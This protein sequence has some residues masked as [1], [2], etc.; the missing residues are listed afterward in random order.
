[1]FQKKPVIILLVISIM[2]LIISALVIVYLGNE[3]EMNANKNKTD[4]AKRETI[5]FPRKKNQKSIKKKKRKKSSIDK[6]LSKLELSES[7]KLKIMEIQKEK[8]LKK[9]EQKKIKKLKKKLSRSF[10]DNTSYE[11][12][13]R[14]YGQIQN[15][16]TQVA[17][18]EFKY[19]LEIRQ[20][21]NPKQKEKFQKLRKKY[22]RLL[23]KK[24]SRR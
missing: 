8:P 5:N 1:M 18:N 14:L 12:M 19:I 10:K 16:K 9:E 6:I 17:F 7:Q 20:I 15:L 22:K 4:P 13:L 24:K 21:L 3:N 23:K 11:E 2:M